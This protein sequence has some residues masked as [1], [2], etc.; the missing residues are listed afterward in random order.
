[1]K[2]IHQQN[3]GKAKALNN[4]IRNSNGEIVVTVDADTQL[5][6]NSLKKI[7]P[8]FSKNRQIGAVAGNVKVIPEKSIMNVVQGTE[9]TVGI[10][11][12]R[13]AQSVLGCV[14]IVPGRAR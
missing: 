3:Q 10:N 2:V 1:M 12:I 13:K 4:C 7:S 11:L 5:E 6:K 14:M 8:R 9:Y